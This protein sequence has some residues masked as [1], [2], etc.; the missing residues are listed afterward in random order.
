MKTKQ[1]NFL[2]AC[3]ALL[4]LG[5]SKEDNGSLNMT[6]NELNSVSSKANK[7]AHTGATQISG[8]GLYADVADCDYPSQS[9]DFALKLTGDLEG[10]L[11]V[12]VED[13]ECSPSGTYR[14]AGRE[15]FVGTYN[16][17]SGSFWTN[18]KFEAKFEGCSDDG[19]FL[20]AE[21][22]GRCQH[23]IVKGSG[24]GVFTGITGRLD[25]KDDIETGTFPYR[26]H[27]K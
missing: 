24:D 17:E 6:Q 8:V 23:P 13:H 25:F 16:G 27:L 20:G 12:F 19:F 5:C 15:L 18:Y 26:G 4:I 11:Y 9:A 7:S 21:I 10:C 14:E 3:V 22:F 1:S 2:I